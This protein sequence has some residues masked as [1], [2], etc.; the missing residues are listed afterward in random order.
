[1][2][3]IPILL[4]FSLLFALS[5]VNTVT[6]PD[7]EGH[8]YISDL[9]NWRTRQWE[10]TAFYLVNLYSNQSYEY[11]QTL[12]FSFNFTFSNISRDDAL[13]FIHFYTIYEDRQDI[14]FFY[15]AAPSVFTTHSLTNKTILNSCPN[16]NCIT[17]QYLYPFE[18][19]VGQKLTLSF[20]VLAITRQ[21]LGMIGE[22]NTSTQIIST[23]WYL[24]FFYANATFSNLSIKL[25]DIEPK[26]TR[27]TESIITFSVIGIGVVVSGFFI[28]KFKKGGR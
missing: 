16:A 18:F 10:F 3:K 19:Q 27:T 1:M 4:G 26:Y 9:Y 22:S 8:F 21:Q 7:T 28:T 13:M 15:V 25:G 20:D 24:Q 11:E 17:F 14:L 12:P 6:A 2:K 23:Y 5:F